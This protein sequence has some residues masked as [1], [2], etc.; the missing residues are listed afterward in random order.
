MRI[1]RNILPLLVG[2]LVFVILSSA[3]EVIFRFRGL[4]QDAAVT[5]T[6]LTPTWEALIVAVSA[7][8]TIWVLLGK[9]MDGDLLVETPEAPAPPREEPRHAP[10]GPKPAE[11][12]VLRDQ[13]GRRPHEAVRHAI[14]KGRS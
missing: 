11:E 5:V 6:L 2:A 13:N 1:I 10:Q 12:Q 9:W 8:W 4:L 3:P 7:A 14:M